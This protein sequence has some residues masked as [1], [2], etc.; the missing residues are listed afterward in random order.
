M[1]VFSRLKPHAMMSLAFWYANAL[2]CSS[3]RSGL[4]RNFSSSVGGRVGMR[5]AFGVLAAHWRSSAGRKGTSELDHERDIEDLLEPAGKDEGDHVAEVEAVAARSAAGVEVERL[6]LLVAI[7]DKVELSA[8][9]TSLVMCECETQGR[10]GPVGEE[11]AAT[12]KEVGFLAGEPL[13]PGQELCRDRLG[14]ELVDE[15]VVVDRNLE[16]RE[17]GRSA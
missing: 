8:S 13:E 6:L 17:E 16:G 1:N 15:L 3:F 14:A 12:E 5:S 7:Q 4:K 9:V 2:H 11:G 10:G